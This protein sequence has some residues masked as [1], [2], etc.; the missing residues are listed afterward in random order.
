[1]P[2]NTRVTLSATG[3]VNELGKFE[4]KGASEPVT[5]YA[6]TGT[7]SARGRLDLSRQRGFS[8]FVGRVDEVAYRR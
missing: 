7:G 4:I 6:L 5:G 1:M 8:R 2:E 3:L